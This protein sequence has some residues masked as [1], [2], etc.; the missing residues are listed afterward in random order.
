MKTPYF[1]D[2]YR[3]VQALGGFHNAHV[4]LCRAGT[5]KATEQAMEKDAGSSLSLAAKHGLIP[6]IH[7][8]EAFRG[9]NFIQRM[10]YFLGLMID[11]GTS[12]VDTLVDLSPKT[13]GSSTFEK[14]LNLKGKFASKIDLQL[15]AYCPLGFRD[16]EPERW[17]L[18][19]EVA[20]KAEFIG[21]LP[22]RDEQSMYPEHIGFRE[23][24]RRL[25][26]LSKDLK[27]PLHIHVDQKN[28]PAENASEIVLEEMKNL[29]YESPS[30]E[31][32]V[33]FVHS[34]SPSAYEEERFEQL[35]DHMSEANVG[36]ICCPSAALSM[37]QL[38]NVKG[39][40]HNSIARVL[41]FLAAGI[42]VRVGSDNINDI[43]SPA[44]TAD[45][46]DEMFVFCNAIRFYDIPILAKIGA[47]K[48]LSE[49]EK[50]QIREHLELDSIESQ[51]S[52]NF[53]RA[54]S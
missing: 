17:E 51:R 33:W 27:K 52:A 50:M 16:D 9:D 45:L 42:Q 8:T 53:T 43:T 38:R 47:G 28:D 5:L 21:A 37:R 20:E 25:L 35:V 31:P 7:Q 49:K 32:Q 54:L 11:A 30:G 1:N 22:E 2:L 19:K 4:H 24:T 46:M 3:E 6:L 18:V 40:T 13:L 48:V 34:I 36:V 14:L 10:E 23:S 26:G 15:G 12:R 29:R 44:A 39:P 41:E